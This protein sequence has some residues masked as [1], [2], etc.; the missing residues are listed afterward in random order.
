VDGKDYRFAKVWV[1]I[2]GLCPLM[3]ELARALMVFPFSSCELERTF[4]KCT[5]IKTI[6]T[7]RLTIPD[8]KACLFVKQEYGDQY[9]TY[10]ASALEK[11]ANRTP[12]EIDTNE[13]PD[14][15]LQTEA[16]PEILTKEGENRQGF[17]TQEEIEIGESLIQTQKL[18]PSSLLPEAPIIF[19]RFQDNTD[20]GLLKTSF[21][22]RKVIL[23]FQG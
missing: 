1:K 20:L 3:F 5:D 19:S 10:P 21:G 16:S 7:N 23:C 2:K 8:L 6:Q 22:L 18:P 9:F 13:I 14:L 4:A 11:Y 17:E 15:P 12:D